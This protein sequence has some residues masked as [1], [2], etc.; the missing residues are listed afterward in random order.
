[1]DLD[2]FNGAFSL[3]ADY[4]NKETQDM[5]VD[6]PIPAS[7]GSLREVTLNSGSVRNRGFEFMAT[8]RK[9]AGDFQF[10]VS[11]NLATIDN[12]VLSLATEGTNITQGRVEFGSATRTEAGHPIGS[13]YGLVTDGI[14]RTQAELDAYTNSEGD[15]IQPRAE[16]GDIRF[17]DLDGDGNI[18]ADDRDFIGSPIPD[19]L[20]G[21]TFNAA[22]KGLDASIFFQGSQGN[23]V[24]A[25]LV[26]WTEGMHNNFNAS[27]VVL[28]RWTPENT[29]TDI[30]RAVRNDPNGNI[31]QVSD[32]YV[33]DGSY[34]RLK[35][36]VLGYT[37]P[38]ALIEPIGLSNV[39]FYLTGRNL[40]TFTDYPFYDPEIGSGAIG[41]QGTE[42]TSRGIDNGYYPQARTYIVGLQVSF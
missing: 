36:V 27:T 2:L 32:R 39:R 3:T 18:D 8:Y 1:M 24:Y 4:Y 34:L 29:N 40:L 16:P 10:D 5:L 17:V 31:T 21:L 26:A 7:S 19:L 6:V 42:N 12:E 13:F 30:P 22:W 23:D 41:T 11:A 25:E 37:L 14:F 9:N 33:K 20:Y 35:N 38:Q 28:D 15:P